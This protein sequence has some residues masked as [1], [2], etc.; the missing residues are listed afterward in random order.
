LVGAAGSFDGRPVAVKIFVG[1]ASPDGST[2]E[3]LAITCQ[4]NHRSL[5]KVLALVV[6]DAD[7]DAAADGKPAPSHDDVIGLVMELVDGKP[8][9]DRPTSQHLLRCK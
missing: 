9:A 2:R 6:G 3:E 4:N 5:T 8:L 1:G 7:T